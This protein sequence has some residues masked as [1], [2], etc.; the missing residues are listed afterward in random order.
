M[1]QKADHEIQVRDPGKGPREILGSLCLRREGLS[2]TVFHVMSSLF[3][4]QPDADFDMTPSRLAEAGP[5]LAPCAQ[6]W[7]P[8]KGS[9]M[10]IAS[11]SNYFT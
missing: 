5:G 4:G 1:T 3:S 8:P 10:A 2:W 11:S 7:V 9:F 6:V